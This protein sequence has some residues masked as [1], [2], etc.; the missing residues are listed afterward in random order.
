MMASKCGEVRGR[1]VA[2]A[3]Q[4]DLRAQLLEA[5]RHLVADAHHVADLQARH[6][7]GDVDAAHVRGGRPIEVAELEV[8]LIDHL[9]ALAILLPRRRRHRLDL[10]DAARR[11]RPG[12]T[13]NRYDARSPARAN[14][15]ARSAG[16]ERPARRHPQRH[17]AARRRLRVVQ[18]RHLDVHAPGR[19]GKGDSPR[20][21]QRDDRARRRHRHRQ[22]R[23]AA[24]LAQHV[25]IRELRLA[26]PD[27]LPRL[28]VD[29]VDGV[30]RHGHERRRRRGPPELRGVAQ[31]V[32]ALGA[33]PRAR[34]TAWCSAARHRPA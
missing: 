9:V 3:E 26:P 32:A 4:G 28:D 16:S 2:L 23:H 19:G 6:D 22:P 17:A 15:N 24:D 5:E 27:G 30:A 25:A 7:R 20:F 18:Q 21:G 29:A 10:V 34:N 13:A 14:A 1:Q 11:S 31:R 8:A 12:N 33:G